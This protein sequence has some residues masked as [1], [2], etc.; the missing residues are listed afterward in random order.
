MK[1]VLEW[2][3]Y[4]Q[5]S[6]LQPNSDG[7]VRDGTHVIVTEQPQHSLIECNKLKLKP[8]NIKL[9]ADARRLNIV[10]QADLVC[11]GLPV[12]ELNGTPI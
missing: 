2:V 6:L 7:L 12:K 1:Q 4:L 5:V 11:V 8:K 10:H 9:L 3:L